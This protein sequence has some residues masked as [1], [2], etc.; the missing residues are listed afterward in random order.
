MHH[1]YF[2]SSQRLIFVVLKL[3]KIVFFFIIFLDVYILGF[4]I[5]FMQ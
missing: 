4:I 2:L 5:K 3:K 1:R